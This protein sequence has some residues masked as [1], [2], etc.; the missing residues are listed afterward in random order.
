[1]KAG[2]SLPFAI[3]RPTVG[4]QSRWDEMSVGGH[5]Q[6]G[7]APGGRN[8]RSSFTV[9]GNHV[10]DER[11]FRPAGARSHEATLNYKHCVP[12]GLTLL[13]L[14]FDTDMLQH[15]LVPPAHKL[16]RRSCPSPI[17]AESRTRTNRKP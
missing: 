7:Q 3:A 10:A 11:A 12:T 14:C 17:L 2:F 5:V 16:N 15:Q 13:A 1:M 8:G 9:S 6:N 4:F